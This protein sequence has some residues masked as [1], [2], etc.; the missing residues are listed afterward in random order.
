MSENVG[1]STSGN[2]KGLHGLYRDSFTFSPCHMYICGSEDGSVFYRIALNTDVYRENGN[3]RIYIR[4]I[5][6]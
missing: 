5:R 4:D 2:P 1:T 3:I 6:V